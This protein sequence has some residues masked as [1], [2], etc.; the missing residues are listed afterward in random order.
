[1]SHWYKSH[2][3]VFVDFV[4]SKVIRFTSRPHLGQTDYVNLWVQ[5][6]EQV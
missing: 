3:G 5:R 4:E 6:E 2:S 1:M